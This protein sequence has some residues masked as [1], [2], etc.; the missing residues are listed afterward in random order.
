MRTTARFN[1]EEIAR[2]A[3]FCK[4]HNCPT[5]FLAKDQG[6]Y[7]GATAGTEK[8]NDFCNCVL[9]VDGCNPD[10]DENWYETARRKFGGDD[11]GEMLDVRWLDAVLENPKVTAL[12]LVV[13]PKTIGATGTRR[14]APTGKS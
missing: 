6:A 3:A 7:I 5:F 12:V 9:Y 1:R 14:I 11:F 2:L 4:A 13:T 8:N 10:V